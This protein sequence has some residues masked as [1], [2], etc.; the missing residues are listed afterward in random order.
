VQRPIRLGELLVMQGLDDFDVGDLAEFEVPSEPRDSTPANPADDVRPHRLAAMGIPQETIRL[1]ENP[2]RM[3]ETSAL[4]A[5]REL[6][7]AAAKPWSVIAGFMGAGKS[8]AAGWWLSQARSARGE[9]R[10]FVAAEDVAVMPLGTVYAEERIARLMSAQ[11]LVL[12]DVGVRDSGPDGKLHPTLQRVLSRRYEHRLR[13]MCT[14][15]LTEEQWM[16]YLH[17]PRLIDRWRE[18][19]EFAPTGDGSMRGRGKP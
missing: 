14:T 13:T 15:N 12:D 11:A 16:S 9:G 17:E 4:A 2:D 3:R 1:L 8:V 5:A 6:A 18:I 19:G 7:S 10:V